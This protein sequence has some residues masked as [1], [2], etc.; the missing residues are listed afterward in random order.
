MNF[1]KNGWLIIGLGV[2]GLLGYPGSLSA[3]SL[4]LQPLSLL[5]WANHGEDAYQLMPQNWT[6]RH[7][8]PLQAQQL[9]CGEAGIT[10]QLS[11][12]QQNLPRWAAQHCAK[13]ENACW[14]WR[15]TGEQCYQTPAECS[16]PQPHTC[17]FYSNCLEQSQPCGETGYAL[18]Y[19][20]PYCYRFKALSGLT[21]RGQQW[22][23]RTMTCLQEALV[24]FV[25]PDMPVDCEVITDTAFDSHVQCY[26]QQPGDVCHLPVADIQQIVAQIE[27]RD[28]LTH[29]SLKQVLAVAT[30][31]IER[32][33]QEWPVDEPQLQFW[34]RQH[35]VWQTL[36]QEILP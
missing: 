23:D 26:T 4:S 22:R 7:S 10:A 33:S 24:T 32:L 28:L 36:H 16:F 13:D 9:A 18:D 30:I 15:P 1:K 19:G 5:E 35:Q 17:H 2:W 11:A 25:V 3:Q 21:E 6:V 14:Q 29:R 31:C 20:Q 27:P 34:Q 12:C 8:C